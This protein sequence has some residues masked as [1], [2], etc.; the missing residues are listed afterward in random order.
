MNIYIIGVIWN[1]VSPSFIIY[2]NTVI[3]DAHAHLRWCIL[4]IQNLFLTVTHW[5]DDGLLHTTCGTPNYV[6]P[7]VWISIHSNLLPHYIYIYLCTPLVLNHA[8]MYSC[9]LRSLTIEAMMG[10]LRT[11]G[12]VEWYSLYCLQVT[13]LLMIRILWTCIKKWAFYWFC[14]ATTYRC[15]FSVYY[16]LLLCMQISAAEFT[17]PPWLSFGAMKLIARILDPNPM[18]VSGLCTFCW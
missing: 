2:I 9:E 3:C 1:L 16:L 6:A 18:T 11:C 7:E 14:I 4:N 5:Q 15:S 10:Q 12:H 13:C 17:C 8:K